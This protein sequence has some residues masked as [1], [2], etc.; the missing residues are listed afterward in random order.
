MQ[1]TPA[2]CTT[3]SGTCPISLLPWQG[4]FLRLCRVIAGQRKVRDEHRIGNSQQP[5]GSLMRLS[6]AARGRRADLAQLE[7]LLLDALPANHGD[8]AV[9]RELRQLCR[10]ILRVQRHHSRVSFPLWKRSMT[11]LFCQRDSTSGHIALLKVPGEEHGIAISQPSWG[12]AL[13]LSHS[14]AS[15]A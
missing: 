4:S 9:V 13:T 6:T 11:T 5:A 12:H 14:A 15:C 3:G 2:A 7:T 8:H 10:L 1:G